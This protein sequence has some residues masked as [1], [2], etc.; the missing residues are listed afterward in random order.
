MEDLARPQPP[1]DLLAA[2]EE[3]ILFAPA[4]ELAEWVEAT[5]LDESGLLHNWEHEHLQD[6][7]VAFLWTNTRN[8]KG[9]RR[10][11][12]TA[13]IPASQGATRWVKARLE[14]QL[15]NW[16]GELPD[17]LITI[18]AS[19]WAAISDAAAC[20]LIE[21][22]LY[23]CSFKVDRDGDPRTDPDGELIWS[24]KA[25]DVEEFIGVVRRYGPGAASGGVAALVEAAQHRPLFSAEEIAE[26]CSGCGVCAR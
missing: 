17:F 21:H 12:G 13:E 9:G 8:E 18:D 20:A 23:H 16:F 26:A 5:F 14:Y 7:T 24:L 1:V 4:H 25:H 3:T 2:D 11:V 15:W 22:E 19:Y 10:I 6:A